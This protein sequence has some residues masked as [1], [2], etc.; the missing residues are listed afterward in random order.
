MFM[1]S[2]EKGMQGPDRQ[3]GS[4]VEAKKDGSSEFGK[5]AWVGRG[6]EL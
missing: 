1:A 3:G 2:G 4:P 5:R 6:R